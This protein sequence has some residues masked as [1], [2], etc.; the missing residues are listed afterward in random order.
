MKV[1]L[2]SVFIVLMLINVGILL[3]IALENFTN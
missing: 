2:A 3:W 1:L